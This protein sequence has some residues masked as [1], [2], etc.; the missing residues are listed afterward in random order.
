M[1]PFELLIL[2]FVVF[3]VL[4]PKRITALFRSLGRGVKD[5]TDELGSSKTKEADRKELPEEKDEKRKKD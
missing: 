4:G 3:L 5:F 2:L 1:G